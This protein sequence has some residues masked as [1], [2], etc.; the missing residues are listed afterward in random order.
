M[1]LPGVTLVQFIPFFFTSK[2]A[3]LGKI[4]VS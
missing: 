2:P 4:I 1:K 3:N